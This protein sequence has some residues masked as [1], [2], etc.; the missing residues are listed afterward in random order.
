MRSHVLLGKVAHRRSRPAKY[1]LEHDVWYTALDLDELDSVAQRTCL[2]SRKRPGVLSFWDHDYLPVPASD[3]SRDIRTHLVGEGIDLPGGRITL[4]TTPRVLG[5]QFNPASFYLCR[6]GAG[7]LAAVV[8]EV[9][10]TY[11]ERHLYTLTAGGGVASNDALTA[12]MSKQ[13]YVSPFI[14]AEGRYRVTVRDRDTRLT[15]GIVEGDGDGPLLSTSLDLRRLPMTTRTLA[16][17]LMRHPL[18]TQR[19]TLL[20]HWHALRLWIKRVPWH[21][22]NP[23]SANGGQAPLAAHRPAR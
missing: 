19:T 17:L 8:V 3:L 2:L 15:I 18:I 5:Y 13:F 21:G 16:W 6:D 22:H 20:I 1:A 10:N 7:A 12:E 23:A 4:V 14:A 11:G 9:H